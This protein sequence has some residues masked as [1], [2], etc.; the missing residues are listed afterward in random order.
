MPYRYDIFLSYKN[1]HVTN[2][3]VVKFEENLKYWLTQE[4][5]GDEPRIFFDKETID[6]GTIWPNELKYGLKVSKCLL[7]IWTPEYFR[8]RWCLSEWKSFEERERITNRD[9]LIHAVQFADGEHYPL[10]AKNRQAL[11]VRDYNA[12][13]EAFWHSL[14]A[15]ELERRIKSLAVSLAKAI[16]SVPDYDDGFPIIEIDENDPNPPSAE[17][18]KL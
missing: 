7:C 8:S 6:F 11:D 5:G 12:T 1:H 16:K 14:N 15:V 2:L 13:M 10:E 9:R 4:L 17:R 18:L 3:W